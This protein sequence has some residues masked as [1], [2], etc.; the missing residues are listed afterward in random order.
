MRRRIFRIAV[1]AL[2]GL[3]GLAIV[4]FLIARHMGS[5][6][7]QEWIGS[8]LQDIANDYLNPKLSF[9]DLAYEYPLTVSLQNLH[10]TADDPANP[11]HT[12]DIIACDRAEISL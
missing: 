5:G 9:T 12:I 1:L 7:I 4:I 11:G 3:V 8:Q 10:L 6:T 2:G